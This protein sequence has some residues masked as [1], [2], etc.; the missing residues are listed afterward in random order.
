MLLLEARMTTIVIIVLSLITARLVLVQFLPWC[1]YLVFC[2]WLV[3]R[4]DDPKAL[5]HAASAAKAYPLRPLLWHRNDQPVESGLSQRTLGVLRRW[6]DRSQP[7]VSDAVD[8]DD[9]AR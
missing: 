3:K 7:N 9:Q 5:D 1:A 6:V 8:P 4:T 2:A